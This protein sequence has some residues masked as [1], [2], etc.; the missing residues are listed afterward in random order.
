MSETGDLTIVYYTCNEVP[1]AFA[2]KVYQQLLKA[3][4][5]SPIIV[6][7]HKPMPVD[8][9]NIVVDL[10]RHH[11]S[12]YRQALI[13]ARAADTRYIALAED[14][15]LYSPEHFKYRPQTG[16]F[17]YNMN[18]WNIAT[19]SEPMFTQKSGGRR[20]LGNL[21]CE[22]DLFIRAMEERFL[23]WRDDSKIDLSV[24]AEPSKYELQLDVS[25]QKYEVFY[26][27][28]PNI[29]FSHQTALSFGGLGTRKRLGEIRA[30]EVP[31]WD[32]AKQIR[33]MYK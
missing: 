32:T 23:R 13:G 28:P 17:A 27:N 12:I 11:L 6:V 1:L 25:I 4:Q 31:Y 21:I 33:E 22:R 9:Q 5:G 26:T 8:A 2:S 7:S 20:N 29:M 24:W 19:W 15:I 18:Y 30:T 14:D 16:K 10:P 3:A